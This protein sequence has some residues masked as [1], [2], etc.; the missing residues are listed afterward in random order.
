MR[1][2][3]HKFSSKY[4]NNERTIWVLEPRDTAKPY[5]LAIFLDAE[6]Y[7]EKIDI[8]SVLN[9]LESSGFGNTLYL[10]VS[11]ESTET[12]WRECPCHP[13]F[14]WFILKE[15]MFWIE[16]QYP[17]AMTSSN[18]ALIGLSY[19]GLAA[20]YVAL[21]SEGLF[22]AVLAQSGSFWWNDC[23]LTSDVSSRQGDHRMKFYL[24]VGCEERETYVQHKEDVLQIVSQIEGVERFRDALIAKGHEVHYRIFEG[25]HNFACWKQT[26]PDAL[27]LVMSNTAPTK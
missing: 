20:A 23:W 27:R 17:L 8:L 3:I 1:E 21:Q 13:P 19:T 15:L 26:L 24:D 2:L 10:F 22:T 12:R 4:A 9:E 5:D 7:R 18:R 16:Q 6:L 11:C 14:A 25:G